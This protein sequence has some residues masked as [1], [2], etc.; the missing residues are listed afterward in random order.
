MLV[1]RGGY[2]P[3]NLRKLYANSKWSLSSLVK[4]MLTFTLLRR[5]K[6][7]KNLWVFGRN[8]RGQAFCL[9]IAYRKLNL[10]KLQI[11]EPVNS[12]IKSK[13]M[14]SMSISMTK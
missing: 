13:G 4:M 5:R 6:P 10:K 11:Y 2:V 7:P 12:C 8:Y 3:F 14:A 1:E 9:Y